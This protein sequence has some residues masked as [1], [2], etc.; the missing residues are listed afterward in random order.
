[1]EKK[2][3]SYPLTEVI[4]LI[5]CGE[6]RFTNSARLG[7]LALGL[8]EVGAVAVVTGLSV[9]EFQGEIK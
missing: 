7:A 2:K 5:E 9:R 8:D 6:W 4:R 3:P 1:M